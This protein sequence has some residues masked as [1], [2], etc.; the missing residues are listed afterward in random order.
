MSEWAAR[1]V[2]DLKTDGSI[3]ICVDYKMTISRVAKPDVYP[4]PRVE[5]LFATLSGGCSFYQ[6]VSGTGLSTNTSG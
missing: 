2:P 6:V 3:R 1:I 5:D 4:L